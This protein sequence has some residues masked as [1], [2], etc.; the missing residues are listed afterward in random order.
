MIYSLVYMIAKFRNQL[1]KTMVNKYENCVF[2]IEDK[3][4]FK[5]LNNQD[6]TDIALFNVYN[7]D[8]VNN[9]F[10]EIINNTRQKKLND[11][12]YNSIMFK[13][14]DNLNSVDQLAALP[15][16]VV[17][18]LDVNSLFNDVFKSYIPVNRSWTRH[19]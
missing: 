7:L 5:I 8:L 15:G 1:P 11:D 16:G 13:G 19:D 6:T 2:N 4:L 18:I 10:G 3:L 14:D 12:L 9:S 17:G